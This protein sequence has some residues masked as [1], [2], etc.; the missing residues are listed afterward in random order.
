MR[1]LTFASAD[2]PRAGVLDGRLVRPLPAG[3][4]ILD[5]LRQGGLAKLTDAADEAM[6]S[7]SSLPLGS[8]TLLSPIPEPPTVR[9]FMTFESHY[10]GT[11]LMKGPETKV[12]SQW[13]RAPAFYFSSPYGVIGPGEEIPI[14]PGCR[15]F[16]FE[17]EV[18]AVLGTGGRD[19]T[20]D[21]AEAAIAGYTIL[22]DWSARDVQF[23]EMEVG[24]GPTKGKD[25]AT[26]L[27][28]LL[29]TPDELEWAR[30]G[31]SFRLAM[32]AA[33][34]GSP[35]GEDSLENMAWSFGEMVAYASRGTEVRPGDVFGSGTC[36]GGC[37][38]E[39][40]GRRGFDAH[41]GLQAQDVVTVEVES[42]GRL[43]CRVIEGGA[44]IPLTPR[45]PAS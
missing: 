34:N 44:P 4:Q 43:D 22:I 27:G 36:G 29:V 42:L 25:S 35:I 13:Y 38:A 30:T 19:L 5:L 39:I 1:L 21:E 20:P 26:T 8:L 33:V 10:A 7:D 12:P 2:G 32:K 45:Q 41:P 24:L 11:L 37:L 16:D 6:T 3:R 14:P 23:R 18:A 17:L 9:D 28:P 31:T 40:W 15:L